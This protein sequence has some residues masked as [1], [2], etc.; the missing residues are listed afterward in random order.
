M[1]VLDF[2]KMKM[3]MQE[4]LR[5]WIKWISTQNKLILILMMTIKD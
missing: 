3:N 4:R 1:N 5:S 2:K